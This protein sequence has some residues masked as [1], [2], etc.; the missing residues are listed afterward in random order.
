MGLKKRMLLFSLFCM[1]HVMLIAQPNNDQVISDTLSY[2]ESNSN[3]VIAFGE[4]LSNAIQNREVDSFMVKL[5]N[6]KFFERVLGGNSD[7]D[8]NDSF[9]KGLLL[10]MKQALNSFPN[11][12]ISEVENGSYYDFISYRYDEAAQTYYALFRLYSTESGMNYHDYRIVNNAGVIQFSDMYIYLT[13]EHFTETLGRLMRYTLPEAK[14]FGLINS[15]HN[16][17][18]DQLMSAMTYNNN[19]EYLK[20]YNLMNNLKSELSQEKFLLIFKTLIASNIDEEKYLSSLEELI[21][22]FP[23]DPTI[24]L[25]K[26]DYYIYKGKYFEAIQVI[27]QLQ[28]ETEDDFLNYVKACV[29]F[30]DQNYDLALNYFKYTIDNY[31]DF[32]EG[33]AGYLNTLV[34]MKNYPEAVDYLD[35]LMAAGYEKELIAEYVEEDDEFGENVL[36]DFAKSKPYKNWKK[37]K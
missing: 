12:I 8:R 35:E 2:N 34:M 22:T 7:L 9:T 23:D 21:T 11:E 37:K 28:N 13:G 17:E 20:A 26:I 1:F 27:N 15:P 6:D 14:I 18:F 19:G 10:G 24:G 29:A 4:F 33:Q 32:F 3:K 30:E 36:K 16:S 25:N 5:N 31:A